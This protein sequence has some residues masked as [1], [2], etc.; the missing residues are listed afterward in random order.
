MP[1]YP[2]NPF[3]FL[4]IIYLPLGSLDYHQL[5]CSRWPHEH[6]WPRLPL[7]LAL[8]R[9]FGNGN[10]EG[11]DLLLH[12][13]RVVADEVSASIFEHLFNSDY[14]AHNKFEIIIT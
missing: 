9:R 11:G 7:D 6:Q 5:S 13:G 3:A 4:Y 12:L 2:G 14:F 1:R 10:D 8:G